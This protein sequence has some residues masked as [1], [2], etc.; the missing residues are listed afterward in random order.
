ML[1]LMAAGA[2]VA[3]VA[4]GLAVLPWSAAELRASTAAFATVGRGI[5]GA[6][7]LRRAEAPLAA[8]TRVTA[9]G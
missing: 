1:E 7:R 3:L 6:L 9:A 4:G 5:A 2:V 8:M